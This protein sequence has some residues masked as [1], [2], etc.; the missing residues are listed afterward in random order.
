MQI[1][2][3]FMSSKSYQDMHGL[4]VTLPVIIDIQ[5]KT[6]ANSVYRYIKCILY[7]DT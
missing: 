3:K 7:I 1:K 4:M 2:D 5:N 6:E